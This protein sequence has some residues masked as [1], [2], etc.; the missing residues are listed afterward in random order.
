MQNYNAQNTEMLHCIIK[1]YILKM[2]ILTVQYVKLFYLS[3]LVSGKCQC[4]PDDVQQTTGKKKPG[5]TL[6]CVIACLCVYLAMSLC[7]C[8]LN[9]HYAGSVLIISLVTIILVIFF[10]LIV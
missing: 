9:K 10:L 5:L 3:L 2:M 6:Q 1:I 7:L 4:S 8:H